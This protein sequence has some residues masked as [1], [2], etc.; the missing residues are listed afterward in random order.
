MNSSLKEELNN[1]TILDAINNY[2]GPDNFEYIKYDSSNTL[3]SYKEQ[4]RKINK[5]LDLTK[6]K[7]LKLSGKKSEIIYRLNQFYEKDLLEKKN[8][9]IDKYGIIEDWDL[10]KVTIMN[11]QI[12]MA[13]NLNKKFKKDRSKVPIIKDILKNNR[14]N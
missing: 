2:S 8:E 5:T 14:K 11:P 9:I 10:S 7:K 1:N 6:N 12:R 13:Y 4:I 3:D